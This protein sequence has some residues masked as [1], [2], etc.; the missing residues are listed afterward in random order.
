MHQTTAS[1]PVI[2]PSLSLQIAMHQKLFIAS[3][4]IVALTVVECQFGKKRHGFG[5]GVNLRG[6][7]GG[8]ANAGG[9]YGGGSGFGAGGGKHLLN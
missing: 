2:L 9:G 4:L 1:S 8:G 5:G 3:L 7:G 6:L